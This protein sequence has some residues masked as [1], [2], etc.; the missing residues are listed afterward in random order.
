[1]PSK[2]VQFD[3]ARGK[4]AQKLAATFTKPC[5]VTLEDGTEIGTAIAIRYNPDRDTAEAAVVL[6]E[7]VNPETLPVKPVKP[8]RKRRPVVRTEPAPTV[9]NRWARYMVEK[10][11]RREP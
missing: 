5:P 10:F 11:G 2:T 8:T 3:V 9:L 7:G 1:M 6:K 4:L